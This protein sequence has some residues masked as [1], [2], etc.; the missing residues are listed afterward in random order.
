LTPLAGNSRGL[1]IG[2]LIADVKRLLGRGRR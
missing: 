1:I 2:A